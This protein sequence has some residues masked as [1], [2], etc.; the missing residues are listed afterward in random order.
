MLPVLV[1]PGNEIDDGIVSGNACGAMFIGRARA[2][3]WVVG[4]GGYLINHG[5]LGIVHQNTL[6]RTEGNLK[7][8]YAEKGW[9][10]TDAWG[11]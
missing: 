6:R 3:V 7:T 11:R 8:W 4:S 5:S 2:G 9:K 1:I 10:R